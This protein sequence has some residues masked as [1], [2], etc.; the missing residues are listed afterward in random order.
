MGANYRGYNPVTGNDTWN[1]AGELIV[2][3]G[4]SLV[5]ESGADP[6]QLGSTT[7]ITGAL[8]LGAGVNI[9]GAAILNSGLSVAGQVDLQIVYVHS[10]LFMA[11]ILHF[12]PRVDATTLPSSDPGVAG[13]LWCDSNVVTRSTG[14]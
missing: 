7:I 12:C 10:E 11:G 13:E 3:A 1:I 4:G 9:T 14:T 5:V 2:K 8:Y 6:T